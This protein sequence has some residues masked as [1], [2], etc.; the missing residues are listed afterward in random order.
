MLGGFAP[1]GWLSFAIYIVLVELSLLLSESLI[2]RS[3][4]QLWQ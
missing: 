3:G 1:F 2:P 4:A